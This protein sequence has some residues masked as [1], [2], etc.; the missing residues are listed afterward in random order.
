[1][2]SLLL[3]AA[4][5]CILASQAFAAQ[6]NYEGYVQ[7]VHVG[8]YA[9]QFHIDGTWYGVAVQPNDNVATA[10]QKAV[11]AAL[12][13]NVYSRHGS[14]LFQLTGGTVPCNIDV[15]GVGTIPEIKNLLAD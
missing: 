8:Q 9:T 1:M 13:I 6:P 15:C 4:V 5:T 14:M 7:G 10:T 2:K 12:I 3:G 11:A